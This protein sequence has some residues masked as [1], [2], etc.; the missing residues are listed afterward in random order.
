MLDKP[1]SLEK[2]STIRTTIHLASE[3]GATKR[4]RME[5]LNLEKVTTALLALEVGPKPYIPKRKHEF[6]GKYIYTALYWLYK[7]KSTEQKKH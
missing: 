4:N 7:Y 1:D 5:R 3:E 2:D 6:S